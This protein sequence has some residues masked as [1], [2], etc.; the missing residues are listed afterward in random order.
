MTNLDS[1]TRYADLAATDSGHD[2]RRP[3][4]VLLHGLTFDRSMWGPARRE[5]QSIDA[6]RRVVALDLPGHGESPDAASYSFDAVV[7]ALRAAVVDAELEA[8]V[9]V[10]HSAASGIGAM[11]AAQFPTSG[12]VTVEGSL[13][14]GDFAAMLQSMRAALEGP[15][16]AAA[17]AAISERVFGLDEVPDEVR[18]F[19]HA[20]SRPRQDVLLG[21][22][23]AM[24]D[25]RP[26]EIQAMVGSGLQAIRSSGVPVVALVGHEPPDREVAWLDANDF[27]E[28]RPR[29]WSGSGHFPHLA[30]PR[31]FAELLAETSTWSRLPA[32]GAGRS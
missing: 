11:Y 15:G 28:G 32:V 17:W 18:A 4:L 16:F 9:I 30:H 12:L 2:D 31:R 20:T 14:V 23:G 26:D 13:M 27:A 6:D 29:V 19:V 24:L 22:W 25:H 7:G 10:G 3:P 1:P 21:Y 8:P 5:L